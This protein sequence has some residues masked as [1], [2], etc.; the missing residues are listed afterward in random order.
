MSEK[1]ISPLRQRMLG[2]STTGRPAS[3]CKT[4]LH[5]V[6]SA[7]TWGDPALHPERLRA[8]LRRQLRVTGC[9]RDDVGITTDD[10]LQRPSWQ[11]WA[12]SGL[13][14]C[15]EHRPPE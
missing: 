4:Y 5:E 2:G 1:P 14:R 3:S 12:T 7:D 8:A 15:R 10:L 6:I 11:G 9:L 13:M